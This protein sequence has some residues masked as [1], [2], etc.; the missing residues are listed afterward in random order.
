MGE[1]LADQRDGEASEATA[2]MDRGEFVESIY[3]IADLYT[4]SLEVSAYVDFLARLLERCAVYDGLF[5]PRPPSSHA[6]LPSHPLAQATPSKSVSA[7]AAAAAATTAAGG[8]AETASPAGAS[9][10][11]AAA[12]I[13]VAEAAEVPQQA[14]S[15]ASSRARA[16]VTKKQQAGSS[17]QQATS[18]PRRASHRPPPKSP[19]AQPARPVE[20]PPP[21]LTQQPPRELSD[22]GRLHAPMPQRTAQST[23][24]SPAPSASPSSRR[25]SSSRAANKD[26]AMGGSA[27]ERS[28]ASA[29]S[30]VAGRSSPA[31]AAGC[32]PLRGS[33]RGGGKSPSSVIAELS[34]QQLADR[35]LDAS[36]SSARRGSAAKRAASSRASPSTPS[37]GPS[38]HGGATSSQGAAVGSMCESGEHGNASDGAR[39]CI[40]SAGTGSACGGMSSVGVS[41]R[42]TRS[43]SPCSSEPGSALSRSATRPAAVR[44]H[45]WR[46]SDFCHRSASSHWLEYYPTLE[47][48]S[49]DSL[50]LWDAP[51]SSILALT[52][53]PPARSAPLLRLPRPGS[54]PALTEPS[55]LAPSISRIR[56]SYT[57]SSGRQQRAEAYYTNVWTSSNMCSRRCAPPPRH[58]AQEFT[59]RTLALRPFSP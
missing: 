23:I 33:M 57:S 12:N 44:T 7:S 31:A 1:F 35:M 17:M 24:G 59:F 48:P 49:T 26:T 56:R 37:L 55:I 47:Y 9:V 52:S 8:D 54:A 34:D 30:A 45:V 42:A 46:M 25:S 19:Q 28:Q 32:S 40:H 27:S 18:P 43:P 41:G 21:S 51:S 15:A 38:E 14:A 20:R 5:L 29:A 2:T 10:A 16:R 53:S 3:E 58:L 4:R 22:G 11:A 6:A 39:R 36:G 13:A 50:Q